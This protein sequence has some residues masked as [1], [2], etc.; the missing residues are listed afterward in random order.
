MD[1][2]YNTKPRSEADF[3]KPAYRVLCAQSVNAGPRNMSSHLQCH[4]STARHCHLPMAH[5]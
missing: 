3:L 1:Y 2:V 5:L 4:F